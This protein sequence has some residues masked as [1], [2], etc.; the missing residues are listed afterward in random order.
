MEIRT[1]KKYG[2]LMIHLSLAVVLISTIVL[3][4]FGYS[5][6][7]QNSNLLE[8]QLEQS[9]A[10]TVER[11]AVGLS[12]PF[13]NY[14]DEGIIDIILSEMKN[15]AVI[16]I[17]VFELGKKDL[18]YGFIRSKNNVIRTKEMAVPEGVLKSSQKISYQGEELGEVHVIMT[19]LYMRQRLL[20][21]LISDIFQMVI[22]VIV[23][24]FL[25]IFTL[26]KKFVKPITQLTT[27][28]SQISAGNLDQPIKAQSNDEI[29]L[30]AQSFS[31]MRDS[32]RQ[33]I[34]ELESENAQRKRAEAELARLTAIIENTSD[35]VSTAKPDRQIT[36]VNTAGKAMTGW[37]DEGEDSTKRIPD[38]HPGWAFKIIKNEGIP[39]AIKNGIWEGE[40]AILTADGT[41]LPVSQVIMSHKSPDGDVEYLS[42]IIRDISRSKRT[43]EQLRQSEEKYRSIFENIQDVYYE[44]SLDGEFLE[45]SPSAEN[46][47]KYKRK[48]LIGHLLYDIYF[49]PEEAEGLIENTL[50]KGSIYEY[51]FLLKDKD[52]LQRAC[53]AT[54][55]LVKDNHGNPVKLIGTIRDISERKRAENEKKK[56][57]ERL[58]RSQ[59]M[60]SLGLLAGGVAHDLNNVLSGIVSYPELILMDLNGDSPLRKPIMTIHE[61]GIRAAEIVQDLLTL[62]R[63]GVI[64]REVLNLNDIV[65]DYF[66]SPESENFKA[67]HPTVQIETHIDADIPYIQGSAIHLKKTLMN[68]VFNA[69]EAQ[70]GGGEIIVSTENRYVDMPIKGYDHVR[71]GDYVVL[72]V[73]DRGVGISAEDLERIFEPFYTKKI[74]GRSGTGLGMAVV[75]GTVQ[76]HKGYINVESVVSQGTTFELFFPLTDERIHREEVSKPM[77]ELMGDR[78]SILVV[79][80]IK[81]QREIA[82]SILEKLNYSVTSV[83]SGEEAIDYLKNNSADLLVLDMIMDPGIDGLDTYKRILKLHPQQKA[84]I[85]SGFS[86]TERVK[87]AQRLGAGRYI[88]KPYTIEKIGVGVKEELEN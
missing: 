77:K 27:A 48:E 64:T 87:E 59:K 39:A 72:R 84:I 65:T 24:A 11:L 66:R 51:E 61:A 57:E 73:E 14:Y 30:L 20:K 13:Y 44:A 63:R 82:S 78:Q 7:L 56:L 52:G 79:D 3:A 69:A 85:A 29:G 45:I 43:E 37:T 21:S 5:G 53:S 34:G 47:F 62:S 67:H 88:K 49:Y 42:T 75:W 26:R 55:V 46:L 70:T 28:S 81:E 16:G 19:S 80:D 4:L 32:I 50:E 1:M 33:Q 35:F 74:M 10:M 25:M 41:E 83:S 38:C 18:Q 8:D 76:D 31:Q 40:T 17:F 15:K 22:L 60:E 36:Y 9:L 68:L 86:E 6:Y 54:S 71:E 58:I 23:L 2:S 12:S